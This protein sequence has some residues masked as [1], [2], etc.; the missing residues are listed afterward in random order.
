VSDNHVLRRLHQ[1]ANPSLQGG[2]AVV[3]YSTGVDG[4]CSSLL[5]EVDST[6]CAE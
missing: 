4:T 2:F 1:G 5:H 6:A 3:L